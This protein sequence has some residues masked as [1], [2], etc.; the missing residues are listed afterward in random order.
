MLSHDAIADHAS[1]A[2]L[3][4]GQHRTQFILALARERGWQ[5]DPAPNARGRYWLQGTTWCLRC[6]A[7]KCAIYQKTEGQGTLQMKWY[8]LTQ[9]ALITARLRG[10]SVPG[11]PHAARSTSCSPPATP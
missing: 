5:P 8:M 10:R 6:E 11:S 9:I 2:G 4:S 3:T 7:G 1:Q